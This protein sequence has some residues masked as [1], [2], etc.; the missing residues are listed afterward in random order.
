MDRWNVYVRS[1]TDG[2]SNWSSE[3]DVSTYVSGS[4][5][6]FPD[7]FRFPFGDYFEMEI[8]SSGTTHLIWGE[9]FSYDSPGSIWYSQGE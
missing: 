4:T 3:T 8:D 7:G 5:Y 1:S 6:I 2:G 9:G